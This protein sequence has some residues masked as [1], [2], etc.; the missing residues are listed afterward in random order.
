VS[1]G[2]PA[3]CLYNIALDSQIAE[4]WRYT[5][6]KRHLFV[7]SM[8]L[9]VLWVGVGGT[10]GQS[11]GSPA[12]ASSDSVQ[13]FLTRFPAKAYLTFPESRERP[14][15]ILDGLPEAWTHRTAQ[16]LTSLRGDPQPGEYYVFQVGV[17]AAREAIQDVRAR[18]SDLTGETVIPGSAVTCFNLEGID[19][20][21]RA[22]RKT[23]DVAQGRVQPLWFGVQM[24]AD[25]RGP[26]RGKLV[27]DCANGEETEI[28]VLLNVAGPVLA[29]KGVDDANRLARLSWLNSTIAADDEVTRG[30]RP[31]TRTGN[32]FDILGRRIQLSD[33]GLPAEILSFFGPNNQ[34]LIQRGQPILAGGFRF[35]V[36]T[37]D[38]R[39]IPLKPGPVHFTRESPST[40][41]WSVRNVSEEVELL[42]EAQP[43]ERPRRQ[44]HPAGGAAD[45]R[46][47]AVHDGHGQDRRFATRRLELEV[48]R[49]E[50]ESG[51]GLARG[52]QRRAAD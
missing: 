24:P 13:T 44:G 38:G 33:N 50:K 35:V 46:H 16:T 43:A 3:V 15:R 49:G 31:V 48:G 25:A 4:L 12:Y 6:M 45:A 11:E 39:V 10:K 36:E 19:Y 32:A 47:V 52:R 37:V 41:A 5:L 42:V 1:L 2:P 27:I 21:G 18:C 26:Y 23:V 22:F 51:F 28:D 34:T 29:N 30:Y 9:L 14:I 20:R 7:T 17:F 8:S 40:L